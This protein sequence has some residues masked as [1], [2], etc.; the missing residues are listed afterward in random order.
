MTAPTNQSVG[1]GLSAIRTSFSA[2]ISEEY[3]PALIVWSN[4]DTSQI[5]GSSILGWSGY[6]PAPLPSWGGWYEIWEPWWHL[7]L[8]NSLRFALEIATASSPFHPWGLI[9][10][11][12]TAM[13]GPGDLPITV[14]PRSSRDKGYFYSSEVLTKRSRLANIS[15]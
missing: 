12:V 4:P 8:N 6:Q 5:P 11:L 2:L 9:S 3:V 15:L 10:D 1:Q 13:K 7:L 14:P